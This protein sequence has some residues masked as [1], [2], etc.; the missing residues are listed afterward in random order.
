[1]HKM[2]PNSTAVNPS[3]RTG[4]MCLSCGFGWDV[5]EH[6]EENHVMYAEQLTKRLLQFGKGTYFNVPSAYLPN[7]KM[8]Y[9]GG[10]YDKLL[11]IKQEWDPNNVLTCLH[12]VASDVKRPSA[13]IVG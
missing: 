13:P 11:R 7:W 2:D 5:N 10:H 4:V 9:W 6:D 8:A 3:F 1:M 12:C